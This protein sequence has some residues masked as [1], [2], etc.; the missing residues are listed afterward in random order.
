MKKSALMTVILTSMVLCWPAAV[1]PLP[2]GRQLGLLLA[3]Q[4]GL[5]SVRR[6][7]MPAKEP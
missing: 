5:P 6:P 4:P 2:R 3:R 7:R 1:A